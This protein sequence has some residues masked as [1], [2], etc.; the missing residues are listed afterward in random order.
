[1]R[2][3]PGNV[4]YLRITR[5][6]W[7]N[8]RTGFAYDGAMRFLRDGDAV[9][10][11]LRGNG[12]G[13][14]AVVRYLLSHFLPADTLE[15]TFKEAGVADVQSRTVD[16]LPAGRLPGKPL[17]VLTDRGVG[18]AAEAF[19][20]AVQQFRLGTVVGA[21]TAGAANNNDFV[22][23]APTFMLSLSYGR[24]VHPVSGSNWEGVGVSPDVEVD[25]DVAPEAATRL[26][27]DSLLSQEDAA[28]S[29]RAAWE[30]ARTGVNARLS[31]VEISTR[32]L[33]GFEGSYGGRTI[34]LVGP[35]LVWRLADGRSRRLTPM[36]REGL[37]DVEDANDRFRFQLDGKTLKV[38]RMDSPAPSQ[39]P[40]D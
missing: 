16:N 6:H 26:A 38:H 22:A 25:P 37:F 18:S 1:M 5:F 3:L 30:W 21:S 10:I 8:D 7:V 4:R 14:R 33:S 19:A 9:I 15:M 13:D 2:I 40:R 17:Y 35:T 36:N 32:T 12:G 24:P 28:A 31:P 27:L 39:F 20:Y 29:D 34:E 23:I 11:D